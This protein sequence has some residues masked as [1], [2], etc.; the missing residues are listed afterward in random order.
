M[1][2]C[3]AEGPG[4]L[5]AE[6]GAVGGPGRRGGGGGSDLSADPCVHSTRR[7]HGHNMKGVVAY[8]HRTGQGYAS[9]LVP[10]ERGHTVTSFPNGKVPGEA[11]ALTT[12]VLVACADVYISFGLYGGWSSR[13]HSVYLPC[14]I[15]PRGLQLQ[16]PGP[17]DQRRV[18]MGAEDQEFGPDRA[19]DAFRSADVR[20]R[21]LCFRSTIALYEGGGS[22]CVPCFYCWR[23]VV[24]GWGGG[25]GVLQFFRS[26]LR[27]R[28]ESPSR[29]HSCRSMPPWRPLPC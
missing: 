26:E 8:R 29:A 6:C 15:S 19:P 14:P 7:Q 22:A 16:C 4:A 24:G 5:K 18:L 11:R 2:L 28:V 21:P 27:V 25:R 10:M 9:E 17:A 20:M 12:S 13:D 23:S 3:S 1:G